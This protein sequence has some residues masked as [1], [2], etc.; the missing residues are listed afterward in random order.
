MKGSVLTSFK[1]PNIKPIAALKWHHIPQSLC[2]SHPLWTLTGKFWNLDNN[3]CMLNF[4]GKHKNYKNTEWIMEL[5]ALRYIFSDIE[6]LHLSMDRE[7]LWS[8]VHLF[9]ICPIMTTIA[10]T[11]PVTSPTSSSWWWHMT[12]L[13][14][15]T[16]QPGAAC[17]RPWTATPPSMHMTKAVHSPSHRPHYHTHPIAHL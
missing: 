5:C 16:R 14:G 15:E 9:S 2:F 17:P 6:N 4:F 13:R 3:K 10:A 7:T 1:W 12:W 11:A 8:S